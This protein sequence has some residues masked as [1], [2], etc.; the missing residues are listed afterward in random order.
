MSVDERLQL[1][2]NANRSTDKLIEI[3]LADNLRMKN[4]VPAKLD[5]M[6]DSSVTFAT[7]PKIGITFLDL[8]APTDQKLRQELLAQIRAQRQ[9]RAL[10]L[11]AVQACAKEDQ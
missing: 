11:N 10:Q 5:R 9:A 2:D 8:Q 1:I 7:L 4:S 6:K 3:R